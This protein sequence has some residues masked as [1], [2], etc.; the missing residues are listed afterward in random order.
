[1]REPV[2]TPRRVQSVVNDG[3]HLDFNPSLSGRESSDLNERACRLRRSECLAMGAGDVMGVRHIDN[4]D[5]GSHDMAQFRASLR[6]RLGDDCD[7]TLH[8]HIRIPFAAINY[9][10]S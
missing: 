1:V 9:A 10:Y 8:L 2:R 7:G 4:V 3:R 6:Q 5:D